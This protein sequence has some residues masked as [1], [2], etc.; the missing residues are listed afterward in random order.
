MTIA[1]ARRGGQRLLRFREASIL[2]V[3]I[4]LAVY[5][6]AA[7]P[8]FATEGNL[9]TISHYVAPVAILAT[10]QV[11]L[12]ISGEI[13]LSV[14]HMYALAPF[15]MHYAISFHG[16]PVLLAIVLAVAAGAVVGLVN[17][18]VTVRLH[19]PSFVTTLGMLFLLNGITL[20]TSHAYPVPI[21]EAARGVA[22]WLG[23]APC[24]R[25]QPARCRR[26]RGA[27]QPHQDRQL[28]DREHAR[29]VDGRPG[30]VPHQLDRAA[31]G[32]VRDHVRLRGGGRDRRDGVGGRI[33]DHRGRAAGC[34]GARHPP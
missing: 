20:V 9:V 11:L 2:L 23:A 10:G 34:A 6:N 30:G 5:F 7:S 8:A 32:R 27:G 17:G 13:D 25:W 31:R 19:V 28:H 18:L 21:P 14:G 1:A 26:G 22:W 15:L 16:V 29:R 24:D 33:G 12:L 4:G 3:A